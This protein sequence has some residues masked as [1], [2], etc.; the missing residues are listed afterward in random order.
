MRLRL[1][2]PDETIR[3]WDLH[4]S[5]IS[6]GRAPDNDVVL[7]DRT[8]SRYHCKLVLG[9]SGSVVIEDCGSRYGTFVNGRRLQGPM[10]VMFDDGI[11]IGSWSGELWDEKQSAQ[12]GG[13]R[14]TRQMRA[15]REP[16]VETGRRITRKTTTSRV[17]MKDPPSPAYWFTVGSLV[18]LTM[19][20]L[21]VLLRN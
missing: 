13:S 3:E 2:G 10:R 17:K 7:E 12:D 1:I 8:V 21:Y 6:V 18:L 15:I 9:T 19:F 14:R 11:A 20:L 16:E 5:S 4:S